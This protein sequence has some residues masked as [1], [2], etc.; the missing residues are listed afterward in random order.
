[1]R[2]LRRSDRQSWVDTVWY[3]LHEIYP[4]CTDEE[5]DDVCTAMAWIAEGLGVE[6]S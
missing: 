6:P 5:W 3:V 2:Q 4:D 1:M